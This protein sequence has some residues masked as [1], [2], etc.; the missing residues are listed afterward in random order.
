MTLRA[1]Q[2]RFVDEYLLDLNATQAAIRAGYSARTAKVQG[3]RLL[4]NANVEAAVEAGRSRM[5][6]KAQVTQDDVVSGLVEE[7]KYRGDGASHGARVTAWTQ[8]GKM[9][10]LFPDKHEHTGR[11]GGP[12]R[13][14]VVIK[15]D[16]EFY[17]RNPAAGALGASAP[18]PVQHGAL[19][20][21]R[22]RAAVG[23]DGVGPDGGG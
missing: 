16:R 12:V 17:P 6:K 23:E 15:R 10:G 14:E 2:Q 18:D 3:A 4:T 1:K 13:V 9:L 11:D 19:Q 22:L 20:N 7:A 8:L 5:R 21:G